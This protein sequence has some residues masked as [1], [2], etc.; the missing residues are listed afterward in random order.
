MPPRHGR[1]PVALVV[2]ESLVDVVQ[3]RN[4]SIST[5]PGGSAANVAVALARLGRPTWLATSYAEDRHGR[6]LAEHLRRD[7]V[8][9]ATDP[10]A[11]A[12]TSLATATIGEDGAARYDF[13]IE[14]RLGELRIPADVAPVLVHACSIA[15]VYPPG[16]RQVLDLL[17][18]L[19]QDA[20]VSYDINARPAITGAGPALTDRVEQ[21]VAL[22]DVVKASDEDL[23]VLYPDRA[24]PAAA[25]HLLAG[26]PAAVVVT[27]GGR[28]AFVV[29]RRGTVSVPATAG[30]RTVDTIGAGDSFGAGLL[31]ELWARGAVGPR[32]RERLH[33]LG[34]EDWWR[35]L[36]RAGSIA[37]VTVSR[38][39]ADPP[40][41]HEIPTS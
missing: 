11:I 31:D 2:G 38:P 41:R 27:R 15:A 21:V 35:I 22:S 23:E 19:R 34:D 12:R 25:A 16:D 40:Y 17:G 3:E 5:Y 20:L 6:V 39:G 1:S 14:W 30:V 36:G 10:A 24:L 18:R 32:A 7:D 8:R 29:S 33:S 4:G 26:G 28:G 37:A 9:P 13:D